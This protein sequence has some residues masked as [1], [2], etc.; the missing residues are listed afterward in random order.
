[1]K[2]YYLLLIFFLVISC[3][4]KKEK[5][6]ETTDTL[7]KE[8]SQMDN[9]LNLRSKTASYSGTVLV[10][11]N[12]SIIF[13]KGFGL[14]N[15]AQQIPN[16]VDTKFRIGSLTKTI[17]AVAILQL[18]EKGYLSIDDKV[19]KFL[20]DFPN[21]ENI[22]IKHLLN[23][24]SGIPLDWRENWHEKRMFDFDSIIKI[25]GKQKL[26]FK[27]G[28]SEQYSNGGYAL[29]TNI[30]E[31]ASGLTYEKYCDKHIFTPAKMKNTGA[32]FYPEKKYKNFA[33]GYE[34]GEGADSYNTTLKARDVYTPN[35]KGQ[36][37]TYSTV[38]DLYKY[39]KALKNGTLLNKKSIELMLSKLPNSEY[40]L[41][42]WL[43]VKTKT[44]GVLLYFSGVSN[45]F[46]SIMY[47]YLDKNRSIIAL[48][49]HQNT[50]VF[51]VS[52]TMSA[53]VDGKKIYN[54]KI[55]SETP[56]NISD[57]NFIEG[58]YIYPEDSEDFFKIIIKNKRVFVF[59]NNEPLEELF[60]FK[61]NN[62]FSKN[63][64]LQLDFSEKGKCL[65]TYNGV[66]DTYTSKKDLTKKQ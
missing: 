62:F 37:S 36:A 39:D 65:W 8:A 4:S 54:P 34:Y 32:V 29:L 5:E 45:G 20:F 2:T 41:G 52:R 3:Q 46:E 35:L 15:R 23:H 30:I 1:M 19:S 11:K 66:T 48:N 17:T 12:D 58:T 16:S 44:N 49:N 57:Y 59:S 64:D 50:D 61:P 53:I 24:S 21:A 6:K 22:Q 14:A 56:L 31:Q 7:S 33:I 10:A 27:P 42:S 43:K 38:E 51:N 25:I 60:L 26:L 28:T 18:Q 63:Y 40:T 55:I 13:S 47:R 9:Y